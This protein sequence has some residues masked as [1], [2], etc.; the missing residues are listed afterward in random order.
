LPLKNLRG[1]DACYLCPN[2]PEF[3]SSGGTR[4]ALLSSTRPCEM[5]ESME[6]DDGEEV[7]TV[8][9]QHMVRL[10]RLL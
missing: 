3:P 7:E 4:P 10:S 6:Q 5:S 8:F 9:A 1:S 2:R